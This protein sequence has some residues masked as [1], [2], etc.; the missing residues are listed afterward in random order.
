[1]SCREEPFDTWQLF[2]RTIECCR[3]LQVVQAIQPSSSQGETPSLDSIQAEGGMASKDY[4]RTAMSSS[5]RRA[6]TADAGAR[7]PLPRRS[8]YAM[9]SR[10]K[11]RPSASCAS[12][13]P[14]VISVH[15]SSSA[16]SKR[17]TGEEWC[18]SS[19][20]GSHVTPRVG[21]RPWG[22]LEVDLRGQCEQL[23]PLENGHTPTTFCAASPVRDRPSVAIGWVA[24]VL[25]STLC[26]APGSHVRSVAPISI[27]PMF[28]TAQTGFL[29]FENLDAGMV[30]LRLGSV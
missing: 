13:T 12:A 1:M 20:P 26:P 19:L 22:I 3:Q 11:R 18:L 21:G 17:K 5:R 29:I 8:K 27:S 6:C 7:Q 4:V 15:A 2:H 23:C 16:I 14:S 24:R 25:M 28:T 30:W 9:P 10:P